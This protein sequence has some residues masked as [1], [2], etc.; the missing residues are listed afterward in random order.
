MKTA[1][2]VVWFSGVVACGEVVSLDGGDAGACDSAP[3]SCT[4]ATEDTDC[5]AHEYCE[6]GGPGRTCQCV[7][8]YANGAS[9]CV[10]TGSI[11]D[12]AVKTLTAWTPVNGALLNPTAVGGVD[13]GEAAFL[14]SALCGL[15]SV[16]QTFD[17][18]SFRKA[19]PL[20]LELS[21][22]NQLDRESRFFDSVATGVAF[23]SGWSPLPA[24]TDAVFH[25]TRLCLP[26]GAYADGATKGK[27]APVTLALGPYQ[28]PTACPSSTIT[29][30]AIDHVAMVPANAGECGTKPG[31]G[32]NFDAEG[33]G[34]WKFTVSG[35][36]T[37]SGGF[38]PGLG[39]GGTRA[40]Q[41]TL[42]QRCD[43][44]RME[45][46]FNVPSIANPALEMFVG[47]G[48]ASV[49]SIS[50]GGVL[51]ITPPAGTSTTRRMCLPP[52]LRGQTMGLTF[53][54]SGG[55]G[56][57]T[58]PVNMR[59]FAD[60]VKVVDDPRCET[61]AGF[62][63]LGF[64][65]GGTPLGV[66]GSQGTTP[67]DA[68][69]RTGAIAAH[70]GTHYLSLE[71][72]ARCSSS[73]YTMLVTVP[74][75]VGAAGPALTLF[76]QAGVN[77]DAQT[78]VSTRGAAGVT[79]VEGVGYQKYTLCL[80]PRYVGRPQIV[81]IHHSGGSGVC[82]ATNY[83]QQSAQIDDLAVTTDPACPAQ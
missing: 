24:F 35:S 12:T 59:V 14:P 82:D 42:G 37:S 58:D 21:Y 2:L 30:F 36:G 70:S 76:A 4:T 18:P 20:V 65:Q 44:A 22:K 69:D 5:G 60:N 32:P 11:V 8:G 46:S 31:V 39:A 26:E 56:V 19:E 52:S 3:C 10:W 1:L 28:Q 15:A 81:V 34:G 47:T 80:N 66:F 13:P 41:I 83:T 63:D 71:S 29:N 79:L 54:A 48:A 45:T 33:A 23:G 77:P 57:C 40:A 9:G 7:A 67:A 49:G 64:E 73:G 27:G 55:A 74:P 75:S 43:G 6:T 53:F 16:R 17:M 50:V 38:V 78:T 72:R 61:D 51:Q 68:I 25:T 62:T